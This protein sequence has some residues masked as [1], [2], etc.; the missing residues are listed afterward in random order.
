MKQVLFILGELNDDDVNWMMSVGVKVRL[1]AGATL[2]NKGDPIPALYIILK[3]ALSVR[4]EAA[5]EHE[6]AQLGDGD[7]VGEMS[8]VDAQ[9]PSATVKA[10]QDTLVLAVSRTHLSDK[11]ARESGFGR[12][13]YHAISLYLSQRLRDMD[14]RLGQYENREWT[15]QWQNPDELDP[16][17]LDSIHLAGLRFDRMRKQLSE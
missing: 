8:F 9:P 11:L 16:N 14:H 12:R 17:V 5:G 1:P 10:I 4:A 2:I 3:G 6:I 13:F 7:I 15:T